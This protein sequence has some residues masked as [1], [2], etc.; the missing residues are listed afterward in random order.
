V[1]VQLRVA[2]TAGVC[3]NVAAGDLVCVLE[4]AG[5]DAAD[6]PAMMPG[7][8]TPGPLLRVPYVEADDCSISARMLLEA[9][10]KALIRG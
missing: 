2:V 9:M 7:P 3:E 1:N 8:H 4:P 6:S 5:L 10:S